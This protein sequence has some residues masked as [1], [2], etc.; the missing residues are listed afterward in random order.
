[1]SNE[2]IAGHFNVGYTAVSQASLRVRRE[3]EADKKLKKRI[4]DIEKRL[5]CQV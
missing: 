1:M 4:R 3:M 5:L 2:E